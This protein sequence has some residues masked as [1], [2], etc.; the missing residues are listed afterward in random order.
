MKTL[1][2]SFLVGLTALTMMACSMSKE[3]GHNVDPAILRQND[4]IN[5]TYG[6]IVGT[7]AGTLVNGGTTQQVRMIILILDTPARNSDGTPTTTR[8]AT[9]TFTRIDPIGKDFT[10]QIDY[11]PQKGTISFT[12][13]SS[14]DDGSPNGNVP[15]DDDV[16]VIGGNVTG[17]RI[18]GQATSILGNRLGAIDLVRTTTQTDLPGDDRNDRRRRLYET[19]V[20][21]Y[22]GKIPDPYDH[23]HPQILS[24]TLRIDAA[25]DPSSPTG[26]RPILSAFYE[27]LEKPPGVLDLPMQVNYE[28]PPTV[29][30]QGHGLG[31]YSVT[32]TGTLANAQINA[33]VSDGKFGP[34]GSIVMK[35]DD[36]LCRT[37][38]PN[39]PILPK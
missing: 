9:A 35:K 4:Y 22:C 26:T 14:K 21:R 17:Q 15:K 27:R 25:S 24:L 10:M 33:T 7:Y 12:T 5:S 8:V 19:L 13:Q 2:S 37:P 31:S 6:P 38:R 29:V 16:K 32:F 34:L 30:V 18:T 1:I 3:D 20:G 28:T 39:N 23:T 11:V 36:P